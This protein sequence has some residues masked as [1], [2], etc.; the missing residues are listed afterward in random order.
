MEYGC[1]PCSGRGA[2]AGERQ[3]VDGD[4]LTGLLQEESERLSLE[5]RR[6]DETSFG[7]EEYSKLRLLL[8][9]ENALELSREIAASDGQMPEALRNFSKRLPLGLF[10]SRD[11]IHRC[12]RLQVDAAHRALIWKLQLSH[13][14][15]PSDSSRAQPESVSDADRELIELDAARSRFD[16]GEDSVGGKQA[17]IDSLCGWLQRMPTGVEYR[18]GADSLAA[19]LLLLSMNRQ[20]CPK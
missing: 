1:G 14:A 15:D 2:R 18:Q 20:Q 5:F 4:L 9:A 17:L 10:I 12:E 19:I 11:E 6:S 16:N 7:L 3:G 13:G 8:S